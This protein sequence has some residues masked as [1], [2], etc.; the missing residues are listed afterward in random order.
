MNLIYANVPAQSS[1]GR[2]VEMTFFHLVLLSHHLEIEY[3][4]MVD[5]F[6]IDFDMI[7]QHNRQHMVDLEDLDVVFVIRARTQIQMV[8]RVVLEIL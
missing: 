2:S 4:E 1:D 3:F 7:H 8:Y 5:H 6:C